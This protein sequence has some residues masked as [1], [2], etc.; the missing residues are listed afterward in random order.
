V[1][2]WL[3]VLSLSISLLDLNPFHQTTLHGCLN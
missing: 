1:N 2:V 3:L